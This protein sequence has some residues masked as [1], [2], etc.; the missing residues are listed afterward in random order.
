MKTHTC[1]VYG[2]HNEK[3]DSRGEMHVIM[4]PHTHRHIIIHCAS[5]QTQKDQ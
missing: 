2:E 5:S 1:A 4:H 3:W